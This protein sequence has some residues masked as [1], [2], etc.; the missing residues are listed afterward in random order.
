MPTR[1]LWW[2]TAFIVVTLSPF[3]RANP[4]PL[5]PAGCTPGWWHCDP[6]LGRR[7][8]CTAQRRWTTADARSC[9]ATYG[10]GW[11]CHE[12]DG[13]RVAV[14]ADQTELDTTYRNQTTGCTPGRYVCD[15]GRPLVCGPNRL[16]GATQG[17]VHC[18]E[19]VEYDGQM[20]KCAR[21]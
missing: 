7:Y 20:A 18:T 16:W 21:N 14:C 5:P 13:G 3:L 12:L 10:D 15:D 4:E 2:T 6:W 17:T 1:K 19:C 8:V 11:G 9:P